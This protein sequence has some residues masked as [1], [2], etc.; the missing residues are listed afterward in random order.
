MQNISKD[1]LKDYNGKWAIRSR[2]IAP[3]PGLIGAHHGYGR[4][5]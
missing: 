2:T 5:S 1:A 4:V 3:L